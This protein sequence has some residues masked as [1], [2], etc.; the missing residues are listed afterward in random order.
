MVTRQPYLI[1]PSHWCGMSQVV[2]HYYPLMW[3][4]GMMWYVSSRA[5]IGCCVSVS[6][7]GG[8]HSLRRHHHHHHQYCQCQQNGHKLCIDFSH[9]IYSESWSWCRLSYIIYQYIY[10]SNN[11]TS[12]H[13][14]LKMAAE[15]LGSILV[16][17]SLRHINWYMYNWLWFDN[18]RHL[19]W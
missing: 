1:L 7:D 17:D 19:N 16:V 12:L 11:S 2:L 3:Y 18:L 6:A 15:N 4:C 10:L 9:S 8:H 5:S 13:L 14:I